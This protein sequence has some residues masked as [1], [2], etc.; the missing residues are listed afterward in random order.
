MGTLPPIE[1]LTKVELIDLTNLQAFENASADSAPRTGATVTGAAPLLRMRGIDK[2]FPGVQA[3]QNVDLDVD[4][5]EVHVLLGENGAGKSTLMKVLVWSVRPRCG[6]DHLCRTTDR[7]RKPDRGRRSRSG[8]DPPGAQSDPGMT[9][10]ENIFSAT[11]R[12]A[13]V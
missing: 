5:G 11:N 10:A 3:L 12:P 2:R 1:V 4:A 9:V 7:R 8:H 6:V 13:E